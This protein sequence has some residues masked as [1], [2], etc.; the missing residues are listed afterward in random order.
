MNLEISPDSFRKIRD[1]L[2]EQ[3]GI[4]LGDGKTVLVTGRLWRRLQILGCKSYED[5][6]A[7]INSP[8]GREERALMI[9]LLTTNETYFFREP[10][11]FKQ[12][13]EQMI[14]RCSYRPLRVWCAASSSGEEPYSL[15]M[16]LADSL[17]MNGWEL[18]ATD[19]SRRV[20]DQAREGIYR[21]E[22]LE[23]M[24]QQYLRDYC[25]RGVGD[26]A[27]R[28]V[29]SPKLRQKVKFAQHNLLNPL[30]GEGQ[31]DVIF[32]RNVLIYFDQN[33]KQR[34]LDHLLQKL[35]PGGWLVLGHC[36][37]LSGLN[38]SLTLQRPSVYRAPEA[39]KRHLLR[40][41]A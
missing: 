9:D 24:P 35:R 38:S 19:I 12:L 6:L 15:A 7:L 25:L 29:M 4:L 32:L 20:L 31:F 13:R 5:Y 11:H 3:A 26:M 27:G 14:P 22:R 18:L 36:E 37:T 16:T 34:V 2:H 10:A 28:M 40:V 17:G 1:L 8:T 41:S 30:V 23:H 39:T 33:T 21:M